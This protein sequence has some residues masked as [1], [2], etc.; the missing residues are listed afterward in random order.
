MCQDCAANVFMKEIGTDC[1][2]FLLDYS[3]IFA[4]ILKD[5]G[6]RRSSTCKKTAADAYIIA[7]KILEKTSNKI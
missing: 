4:K 2:D 7:T 5:F 1:V 3:N 6:F